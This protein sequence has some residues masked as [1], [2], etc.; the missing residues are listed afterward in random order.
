MIAQRIIYGSLTIAVLL[1]LF[2]SDIRIAQVARDASGA[3]AALLARGSFIPIALAA[4]LGIAAWEMDRLFRARGANPMRNWVLVTVVMIVLTPWLSAAGW[5]GGG[6][7]HVEGF[8]NVVMVMAIAIV[9]SGILAVFRGQPQGALTDIAATA[10]II[11]Y[12]GFLG[13]FAV[14]LRSGRDIPND[15]GAWLLLITILVIKA[16]DIG[17]FFTGT[18]IGKR[19]LVPRI[20]PA[21]TVEGMAGGL[22][23]SAVVATAIM[24]LGAEAD[25]A[26]GAAE[27]AGLGSA[28]GDSS[29]GEYQL[30]VLV[31]LKD[32]TL[33]FQ[34]EN[35]GSQWTRILLAGL[36]GIVMSIF[37]QIGDL[38]ESC[39]KRD[40]D[41]KDSGRIIPRFGG[42][43]D[44]IDSPLLA[45][46]V[47]WY[48]LVSVYRVV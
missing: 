22:I 41:V 26:I 32:A 44:L 38:L 35:G 12:V 48:V 33:C 43:L 46:P 8:L 31:L 28:G 25:S 23:G 11:F 2:M 13:S 10:T 3:V 29:I 5:L 9:G 6:P 20:S 42:I 30:S 18:A 4:V 39:F 19:K 21:K 7:A 34:F 27:N 45:I 14:Q 24:Y 16:S 40:A 1:L 47:A 17:A 15:Q 37:G 36:F